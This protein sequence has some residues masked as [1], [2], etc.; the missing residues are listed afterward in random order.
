MADVEP[1]DLEIHQGATFRK[2]FVLT[3][4][5]TGTPISI[6]SGAT[7]IAQI[8]RTA[9][10]G[11]VLHEM[12]TE[13]GGITLTHATGVVSLYISDE[14][15]ADFGFAQ[16]VWDLLVLKTNGETAYYGLGGTVYVE[17][18]VTRVTVV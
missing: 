1:G 14:D 6:P 12:T 8:R 13:N 5:A 16:A 2:V 3:D 17:P 18:A 10:D 9:R 4:E 15:T 7:A 11:Y